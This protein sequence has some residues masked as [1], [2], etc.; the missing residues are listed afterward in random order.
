MCVIYAGEKYDFKEFIHIQEETKI[1]LIDK[2]N[3]INN[4]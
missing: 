4:H 2:I 1:K 3:K